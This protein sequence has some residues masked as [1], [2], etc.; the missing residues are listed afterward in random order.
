MASSEYDVLIA[1]AGPGGYIA[2]V[3]AA[4]LGL[5]TAIIEKDP[6]LGGTCLL[7]GCIPTKAM[8]HAADLLTEIAGA[9]RAGIRVSG[10]E[11]DF[12]GVL[13]ATEAAVS[14][15]SKGVDYLMKKNGVEVVRGRARL[16]GKDSLELSGGEGVRT[17]HA[18]RGIILAMG[19]RPKDIGAFPIDGK[20]IITSDHLLKRKEIPA[21][22]AILGA[23]AVGVEFAS[24]FSRFGSKVTL[25]EMLPRILP[26][27][28]E[29][30]S[31]EL[32]RSFSKQGIDVRAGTTLE[33]A[34]VEDGVVKLTTVKDG[35]REEIETDVL[36][37][38][39]GRSANIEDC[40]LEESKI[41]IEKGFVVVDEFLRTNVPGVYAIGDLVDTP[42][43]AHTA[44]AEGIIAAE[45][46]AGVETRPLPYDK[47]PS[48]TYCHPEVA[49]VGLSEAQAKERGYEIAVG[50]FPWAASGK[51]RILGESTGFVKIVRDTRYD[52]ILGVHIIGPHAT[53]LIGEACA[54]LGL[55][56]T[57][58]ELGRI[59]H[60]H[61]TLS[62]AMMEASHAAA[63][64]PL[65]M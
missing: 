45:N 10:A 38:A 43:L 39:A 36:L 54:L 34:V 16:V 52:E 1:G 8:L 22:L 29:E 30:L 14:K 63:G 56:A 13:K 61:P 3:R 64:H 42:Q 5:S 55:E 57:N 15:N 26:I 6:R 53:D 4:Q 18:R 7:R 27:E 28:D 44:S 25:L 19:S 65:G 12:P 31:K 23:G 41:T 51:A 37:V 21:R 32:I 59:V 58:E 20:Y 50:R 33:S 9:K 2:A 40:G 48:C 62:E 47:T 60:P 46:I 17:L 11:V 35:S 24:V 49:S